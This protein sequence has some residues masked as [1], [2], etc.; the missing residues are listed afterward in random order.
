[1]PAFNPVAK[2]S[3]FGLARAEHDGERRLDAAGTPLYMAPE[4]FGGREVGPACDI[5]SLGATY[6]ALLT[7]HPPVPVGARDGPAA[8]AE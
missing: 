3:D 2:L 4:Q 8:P 6:F 1:M 5:Y 7:G